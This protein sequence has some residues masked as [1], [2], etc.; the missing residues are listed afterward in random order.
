MT[1]ETLD[2][3]ALASRLRP[4]AYT[5]AE[6]Y[7]P[8]DLA[9]KVVALEAEVARKDRKL[10]WIAETCR[11]EIGLGYSEGMRKVLLRNLAEVAEKAALANQQDPGPAIEAV[12][13]K[14][15]FAATEHRYSIDQQEPRD[16]QD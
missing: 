2:A 15:A 1:D 12:M 5:L 7:T 3:K 13:R 6:C 9:R 10:K 4:T 14:A 8:L 11:A 16:D